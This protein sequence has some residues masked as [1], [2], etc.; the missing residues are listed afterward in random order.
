MRKINIYFV[1]ECVIIIL[2]LAILGILLRDHG[3]SKAE[4]ITAEKIIIED[5]GNNAQ[6]HEE[7]GAVEEESN[8][9]LKEYEETEAVEEATF[10]N[11][12]GDQSWN[13]AGAERG[14]LKGKN[15]VVFSDSIWNAARGSDGISEYIQAYTGATVYNCAVGGSTAALVDGEDNPENWTSSCF[16]GMIY[17]A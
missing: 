7:T 12:M 4:E 9:T 6:E 5:S 3:K 16:N 2:L 11:P 10:K 14:F 8:K 15:I 13:I 1:L 17:I